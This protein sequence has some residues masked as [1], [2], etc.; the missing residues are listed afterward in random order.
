MTGIV[1]PPQCPAMRMKKPHISAMLFEIV[2]EASSSACATITGRANEL[3]HA[4]ANV[5][6]E[7]LIAEI[8][9]RAAIDLSV[10]VDE[11]LARLA[12]VF[13]GRPMRWL[14]A[15]EELFRL[16]AAAH[17]ETA[18]G[19]ATVIGSRSEFDTAAGQF[20]NLHLAKMK[21]RIFAH[22]AGQTSPKPKPWHERNWLLAKIVDWI[23]P[24]ALGSASTFIW[25]SFQG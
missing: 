6:H 2:T 25:Q 1:W 15:H 18:Q 19:F 16:Y 11:A 10:G 5:R 7:P 8:A 23:I 3:H 14:W 24:F 9:R 12:H 21:S 17:E 13:D 20:W 22:A 4:I